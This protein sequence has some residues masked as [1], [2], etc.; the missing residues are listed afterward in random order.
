MITNGCSKVFPFELITGE[1]EI[2]TSAIYTSTADYS[3][4]LTY[5]DY[6]FTQ[7][8]NRPIKYNGN[9]SNGNR[10]IMFDTVAEMIYLGYE[11]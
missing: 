10:L 7:F 2:K 5:S 3:Q 11:F 4:F 1:L 8:G 9:N 6:I